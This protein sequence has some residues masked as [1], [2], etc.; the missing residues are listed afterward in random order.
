MKERIE[1]TANKTAITIVP[2]NSVFSKPLLLPKLTSDESE[3]PRAPIPA[4]LLCSKTA[5]IKN[6]DNIICVTDKIVSININYVSKF[7]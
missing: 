6:I 5:M 3:P 2:M 4:D 1:T 7:F